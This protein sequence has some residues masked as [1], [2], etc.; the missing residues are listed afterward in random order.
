MRAAGLSRGCVDFCGCGP[1]EMLETDTGYHLVAYRRGDRVGF[2][3]GR[4]LIKKQPDSLGV[5]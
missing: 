1:W 2:R 4:K 5:S 3:S